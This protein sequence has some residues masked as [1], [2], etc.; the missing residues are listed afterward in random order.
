MLDVFLESCFVY[1]LSL[2]VKLL[3]IN[4]FAQPQRMRVNDTEEVMQKN[5]IIGH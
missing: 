4:I 2:I 3:N 1:F 5:H